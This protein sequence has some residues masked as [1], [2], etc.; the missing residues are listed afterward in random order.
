[1][2]EIV[3]EI[4]YFRTFQTFVTLILDRVIWH[5]VVYQSSTSTYVPNVVQIGKT[6][7]GQTNRHWDHFIRS[8]LL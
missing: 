1:V 4:S 8:T 7:C 3:F 5:T 6:F 2:E